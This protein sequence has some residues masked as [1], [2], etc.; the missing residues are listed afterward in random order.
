MKPMLR[1]AEVAVATSVTERSVQN[2]IRRGLLPAVKLEGSIRVEQAELE[3][4]IERR[5][6]AVSPGR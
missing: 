5:A 1:L 4:F 2:W 3:K 6:K